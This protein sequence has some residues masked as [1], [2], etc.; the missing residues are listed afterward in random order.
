MCPL[1]Y[2]FSLPLIFFP[3]S[4]FFF[5]FLF[6]R[7]LLFSCIILLPFERK[8]SVERVYACVHVHSFFQEGTPC[9]VCNFL[10]VHGSKHLRPLQ[11]REEIFR[12][13]ERL[14]KTKKKI[15]RKRK[16][17]W[18]GGE[19]KNRMITKAA[20]ISQTHISSIM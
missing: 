1:V 12:E 17:R 9:R 13:T 15:E 8:V 2:S 3:P 14:K 7:L 20:R 19:G 11:R 5:V 4:S 16:E 6:I 10:F 18:W